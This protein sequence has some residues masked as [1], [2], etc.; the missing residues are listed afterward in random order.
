MATQ[1]TRAYAGGRAIQ[2]GPFVNVT[3]G[4]IDSAIY[5]FLSSSSKP[6]V[7]LSFGW[8]L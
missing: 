2:R 6:V 8:S 5:V 1:R 3:L 4:P 7:V